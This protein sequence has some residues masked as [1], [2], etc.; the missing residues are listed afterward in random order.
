MYKRGKIGDYMKTIGKTYEVKYTGYLM[1]SENMFL[2]YGYDNWSDVS[3]KKMRKL[4]SCYKIE[5]TVPAETTELNF[6]FR[7]GENEWDNNS[8]NNWNWIPSKPESYEYVE[9]A[10][11]TKTASATKAKATTKASASKAKTATKC[12]AKT[13]K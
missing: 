11:A 13:K 12:A 3:E 5:V 7:A 1:N 8:G 6:C 9:I 2:H 10:D 4:K